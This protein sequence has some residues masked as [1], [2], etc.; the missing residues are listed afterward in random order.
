MRALMGRLP[1]GVARFRSEIMR[2]RLAG[3]IQTGVSDLIFTETSYSLI[4]F[5]VS[6]NIPVVLDNHNVE[7]VLFERYI[8]Q[9]QSP[10][11]RA[12]AKI[13]S[14]RMR[15]WD[16]AACMRASLVLAC[17][18]HD[19]DLLR[20]LCPGVHCAVVPNTIDTASYRSAADSGEPVV[21]YTGAG[22]DWY[23]NRD[24]VQFF[25]DEILPSVRRRVPGA[26][27]LVAGRNPSEQ[28][29]R[30]MSQFPGVDLTG[31]VPDMREM[32]A[33]A[34]VC[35]VP[36]RIGSGTRLKILEAAA[37]AKPMVSTII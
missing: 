30:L 1:Y 31:T 35:V 37:M 13:E 5:P 27:F 21:L 36:L 26:R 4:N 14:H 19:R 12:Y 15:R 22:M 7:C 25:A 9:A 24:A 28:F 8:R 17:S 10:L 29:R 16:Q 2:R 6:H 3:H 18:G 23:P 32:F 33:K 34:A 11:H 20:D